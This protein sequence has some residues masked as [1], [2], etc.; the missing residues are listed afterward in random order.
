M[1]DGEAAAVL[2]TMRFDNES[3]AG[4]C[5]EDGCR[6]L[7]EWYDERA[8]ALKL[9]IAALTRAERVQDGH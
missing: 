3:L 7:A 6:Y 8:E 4:G 2:N 9:A 5:R 1:T